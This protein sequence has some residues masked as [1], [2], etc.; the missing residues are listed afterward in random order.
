MLAYNTGDLE[1]AQLPNT[2][3]ELVGP[4]R[5]DKNGFARRATAHAL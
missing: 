3:Q 2:L 1:P 4:A 5:D